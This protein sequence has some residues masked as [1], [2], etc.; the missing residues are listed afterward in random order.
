MLRACGEHRG[1]LAEPWHIRI[2]SRTYQLRYP[3]SLMVAV[4]FTHTLGSVP[5]R[6]LIT[7]KATA[8]LSLSEEGWAEIARKRMSL[9]VLGR[10]WIGWHGFGRCD[11]HR[12]LLARAKAARDGVAGLRVMDEFVPSL[13]T[14]FQT[15]V[16][17]HLC[18]SL[19]P[20]ITKIFNCKNRVKSSTF[21]ETGDRVLASLAGRAALLCSRAFLLH[22]LRLYILEPE[23][24][25][26]T[27][28]D[29]K[30]L[31]L[32]PLGQD[33]LG[34]RQMIAVIM[35]LPCDVE[36]LD[37]ATPRG[38]SILGLVAAGLKSMGLPFEGVN[39]HDLMPVL[40]GILTAPAFS[41]VNC[42]AAGVL[43][44]VADITSC[45]HRYATADFDVVRLD[46]G[47]WRVT[48]CGV[49]VGDDT[50]YRE[51][52]PSD[53]AVDAARAGDLVKSFLIFGHAG[54]ASPEAREA[55]Q[56]AALVACVDS[57]RPDKRQELF[58]VLETE[59]V[60]ARA[61]KG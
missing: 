11:F 9:A 53:L 31:V 8:L 30:Y 52:Y 12:Y 16:G 60:R 10:R 58:Y 47:K 36:D 44:G 39:V 3:L 19:L 42:E 20:T 43:S 25:T 40:Y 41:M 55:F 22:C 2:G 15:T 4:A 1:P 34:G 28:L 45:L 54:G 37:M 56:T 35:F 27:D 21:V 6:E 5:C 51:D 7:L 49:D 50:L 13:L 23:V 46:E 57:L 24:T 14:G 48:I 33:A 32:F 26:A 29:H 61:A 18:L 17:Y 59:R 38:I